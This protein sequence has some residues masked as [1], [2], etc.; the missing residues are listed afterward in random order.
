MRSV[1]ALCCFFVAAG[2]AAPAVLQNAGFAYTIAPSGDNVSFTDKRTGVNYCSRPSS[3]AAVSVGGKTFRVTEAAM[4]GNR[5]KLR[6]GASGVRAELTVEQRKTYSTVTVTQVEGN[7]DSLTFVDIPLTLGGNPAESFGA[8]AFAL[9]LKTRVTQLPA[10]QSHIRCVCYR[11]FGLTGAAVALVGAPPNDLL[12]V[13]KAVVKG[14]PAVPQTTVSGPWAKDVAFNRGSYLFNFGTLTEESVDD[15]IAMAKSLGFNQIDN[16][17]G[18]TRFFRFGDFVLD[19]KKWPQGWDTYKRIVGKLGAAGI[20]SIFHTYAFFIDKGSRY[21]TPVPHPEL[22]AF[23]SFTLAEPVS[24]GAET[25]RVNESTAQVS[26]VTGFFVRNSV[27]L[28]IGDELVTFSGV[29]KEPPYTFTGVTRGAYGTKAASHARGEKARHLKECFG[30]FV[31]DAESPLFEEIAA[32]HA[33]I[34]NH[35]GFK[36]IYL[37][38]IDGSDILRGGAQSW[39]YGAKFV[40]TIWEHLDK[41]VGMEMSAMWHHFWQFRSR[42]QAW[43]YPNRGHKRFIDKHAQAIN[44]GLLLPLHL[45]WW[46]FQHFQPPQVERAFPDVIEYLGCKLIGHDAGISL[47]GAIDRESLQRVPAYRRL[48]KLLK[49]YEDLRHAQ[50]FDE[51]VR[52]RLRETGKEFTLFKDTAGAW[53]F[54]PVTYQSRTVDCLAGERQTWT[55]RNGFARQ[56]LRV[57]IEALMGTGPYDGPAALSL[58]GRI[59]DEAHRFALAYHR[60]LRRQ[61]YKHTEL[62]RIPGVGPAR[63]KALVAHFG[64]VRAIRQATVEQ[65]EQVKGI[66]ARQATLIYGFL[67]DSGDVPDGESHA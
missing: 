49:T 6:F 42:W 50:Y 21:V 26:T 48:V 3:C 54:R 4:A 12:G 31:P 62:D 30:L 16:H 13:L 29:S 25:L 19:E 36:G 65:L 61:P 38:A 41:P 17:G 34:V 51:S 45:G 56:P 66:S 15:W 33:R 55:V 44:G 2:E 58:L 22:D 18:G 59:R 27:T 24:A 47:T 64:S 14:T 9:N 40:R 10:L 43:D 67:H 20:G 35:C 63:K 28:H 39:Y 11:E 60:K 37:D 1:L 23:R 46:N 52:K 8:C 5:L 57:R 7:P 53:R 32:N